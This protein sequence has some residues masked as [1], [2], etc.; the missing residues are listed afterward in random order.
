MLEQPQSRNEEILTAI[1]DDTEYNKPPESRIEGLL[2]DLKVKINNMIPEPTANIDIT[3]NAS[4]IDVKSYAT[5]NV[6]V[7]QGVFPSG[8]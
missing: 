4:N 1:L 6:S 5:A 3:S 8:V 7:P 2:I